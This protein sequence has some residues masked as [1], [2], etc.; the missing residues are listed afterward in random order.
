MTQIDKI[1]TVAGGFLVVLGAVAVS[2]APITPA[3]F[4]PAFAAQADRWQQGQA[5][6][7]QQHYNVNGPASDRWTNNRP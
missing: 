3:R 6:R 5:A 2:A 4:N 7:F 1:L